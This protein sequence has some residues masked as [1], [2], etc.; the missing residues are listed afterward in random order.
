MTSKCGFVSIIGA[1]NAGKSTLTNLLVG[2]KVTIVSPKVQTTRGSVKGIMVEGD[3]QLIFCD[4][5]GIFK[6]EGKLEKAIVA[7]ALEQISLDMDIVLLVDAVK[8]NKKATEIIL[9]QLEALDKKVTLAI[10]KVDIANKDRLLPLMQKYQD[11]GLFEKIFLISAT[12]NDGVEDLKQHLINRAPES[13]FL[14]PEDQLTDVSSRFLA[15]EITREKLF[16]AL[17]DELPYNLSVETENWQEDEKGRITI[18]QTIYV[19]K[20]GQRKIII[21]KKG[22][23]IKQIGI[24]AREELAEIFGTKV[25]LYL[26]VKVREDWLD[27]PYMYESMG[28]KP[29]KK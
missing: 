29:P 21:G 28:L 15:A 10:N 18:D 5:P 20:E 13:P 24:A 17:K 26:H 6:P 8:T 7:H 19:M 22:Q 1:P 12:E 4:T 3:A 25:H 27:K 16:L 9:Q 14:Y 2:G 23:Q 11:T